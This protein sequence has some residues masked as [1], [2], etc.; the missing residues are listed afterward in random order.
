MKQ[1][2]GFIELKMH[3]HTYKTEMAKSKVK[4]MGDHVVE[5]RNGR[6][7][8]GVKL[9]APE[10]AVPLSE[11]TADYSPAGKLHLKF[12]RGKHVTVI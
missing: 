12:L 6:G 10:N 8:V 2:R 4:G 1:K 3:N 9:L 5:I 11:A 7:R